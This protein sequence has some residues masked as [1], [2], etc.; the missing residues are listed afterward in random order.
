MQEIRWIRVYFDIYHLFTVE[1]TFLKFIF[2]S[3]NLYNIKC[4]ILT[5]FSIHFS[6]LKTCS[7]LCNRHHHLCVK[8]TFFISPHG[9]SGAVKQSLLRISLPGQLLAT[10]I[11]SSASMNL[12]I[13]AASYKWNHTVFILL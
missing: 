7:L 13:L 10:T 9:N 1:V 11:L 2:Q 12:T 4:T 5:I 6:G 8:K 3:Q